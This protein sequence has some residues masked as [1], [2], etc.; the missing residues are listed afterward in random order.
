M[1]SEKAQ[2]MVARRSRRRIAP[3]AVQTLGAVMASRAR[4]RV[5]GRHRSMRLEE[6]RM[7]RR[8]FL[9]HHL[10][11]HSG[12]GRLREKRRCNTGGGGMANRATR[13][14][15]ACAALRACFLK[16]MTMGQQKVR[17]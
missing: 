10:R 1:A 16:R 7:M 14:G 15:V 6:V 17:V 3:V 11:P 13:L 4:G 12:T 8:R 9:A 2:G 5:C